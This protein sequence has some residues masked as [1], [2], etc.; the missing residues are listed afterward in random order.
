MGSGPYTEVMRRRFFLNGSTLLLAASGLLAA[1]GAPSRPTPAATLVLYR[2]ETAGRGVLWAADHPLQQGDQVF[3]HQ[4]PDGALVSLRR[5]ELR[6]VSA[7]RV[8]KTG[9]YVDIGI[10]GGGGRSDTAVAGGKAASDGAPGA[11]S[12]GTALFNPARAYRPEIDSKQV[13]GLNLGYPNSPNDYREGR[14]LAFPAP[15][16]VQAAPGEPPKMPQ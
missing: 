3:F 9:G 11:R 2:I 7:E 4:H 14:T 6:R 12:D 1:G 16:A 8:A 5:S 13:P 10:T 15:S